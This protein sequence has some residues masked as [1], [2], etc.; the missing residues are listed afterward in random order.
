MHMFNRDG[1]WSV[2][3]MFNKDGNMVMQGYTRGVN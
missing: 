1:L 2:G 3:E